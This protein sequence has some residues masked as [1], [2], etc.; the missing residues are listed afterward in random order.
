MDK[1]QGKLADVD[2]GVVMHEVSKRVQN[3]KLRVLVVPYAARDLAAS[4]YF[5]TP[6]YHL[7]RRAY[8]IAEV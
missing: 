7:G 8:G 2:V 5:P 3:S 1:N 4:P 6:P